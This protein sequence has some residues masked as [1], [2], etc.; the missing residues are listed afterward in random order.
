[1]A[2]HNPAS[3]GDMYRQVKKIVKPNRVVDVGAGY[4]EIGEH[5]KKIIPDCHVIAVEIYEP[6]VGMFDLKKKY[7]EV[8]V[9]DI[10]HEIRDLKGDLIIFGDVLE[11]MHKE[12]AFETVFY[13][14]RRFRWVI[15]NVPIGEQFHTEGQIPAPFCHNPHE[16]HICGLTKDDFS[17]YN[18]IE[19]NEYQSDTPNPYANILIKG[20]VE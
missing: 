5:I 19:Y 20:E 9:G 1:M 8:I 2:G 15:I 6:Y 7:D 4:G 18:I 13:A 16:W 3:N 14:V 12:D 10:G 17:N 11:H